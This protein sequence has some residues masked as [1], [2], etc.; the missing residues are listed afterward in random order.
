MDQ[1]K[2]I[3]FENSGMGRTLQAIEVLHCF[4]YLCDVYL[5]KLFFLLK[6]TIGDQKVILLNTHLESMGEHSKIR[7]T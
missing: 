3:H 1:H 4:K 7:Y 2:V 5:L 6:G